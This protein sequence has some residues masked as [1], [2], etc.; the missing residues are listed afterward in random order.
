MREQI[1][2]IGAG[3]QSTRISGSGASWPTRGQADVCFAH[4][5]SSPPGGMVAARFLQFL[6]IPLKPPPEA[7]GGGFFFARIRWIAIAVLWKRKTPRH[8]WCA[9]RW[10]E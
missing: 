9:G 3:S 8:Q 10:S 4:F 7:P 5:I 2:N 1:E 6:P